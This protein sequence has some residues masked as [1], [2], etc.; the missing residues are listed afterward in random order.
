MTPLLGKP[1]IAKLGLIQ[2][3]QEV[4]PVNG[5]WI[6]KYPTL[7]QGLGLM[8]NEVKIIEVEPCVQSVPRRVGVTGK[9]ALKEELQRMENLGVIKKNEQPTEWCSLCA[10]VPKPNGK[11]RAGT[12]FTNSNKAVKCEF[13]PLLTWE[14]TMSDLAKLQS[15]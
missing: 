13:Q 7:F 2:F 3:V 8:A 11:L 10:L 14:E 15:I 1:A 12:Y 5:D 9:P 6:H 4:V